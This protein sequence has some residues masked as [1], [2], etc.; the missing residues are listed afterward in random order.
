IRVWRRD[1]GGRGAV[2]HQDLG[3]VIAVEVQQL[4]LEVAVLLPAD[5][6]LAGPRG[7]REGALERDVVA[8]AAALLEEGAARRRR[9]GQRAPHHDVVRRG[10]R[11]VPRLRRRERGVAADGLD[12]APLD[13]RAAVD[14]EVVARENALRLGAA[15]PERAAR[16]DYGCA[17]LRRR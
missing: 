12:G 14:D 11:R 7:L 13:V 15:A 10:E 8:G 1:V 9:Y 16:A 17:A 3:Q 5:D 6:E 4:P 2:V